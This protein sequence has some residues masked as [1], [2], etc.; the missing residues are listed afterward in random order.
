MCCGE[1][2]ERDVNDSAINLINENP[3]ENVSDKYRKLKMKNTK[4]DVNDSVMNF[5]MG[6]RSE[7][8]IRSQCV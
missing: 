2:H 3:K 4:K 7:R 5:V 6:R 1:G 8:R